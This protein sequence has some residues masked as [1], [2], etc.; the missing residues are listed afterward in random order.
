[1]EE[2]AVDLVVARLNRVPL[3]GSLP[4]ALLLT[5]GFAAAQTATS[6]NAREQLSTEVLE[7]T[8]SELVQLD[9]SLRPKRGRT[10][11]LFPELTKDDFELEIEGRP[12]EIRYAD[13]LCRSAADRSAPIVESGSAIPQPVRPNPATFVFYFELK[14]LTMRGLNT[15]IEMAEQLIPELIQQGDRGIL[16]SSGQNMIQSE[17]TDD[18]NTLLATLHAIEDDPAQWTDYVYAER[19]DAR[20]MEVVS[21]SGRFRSGLARYYQ[22]EEAMITSNRLR[23]LAAMLG[24]LAGVDPPKVVFYFADRIR[25]NAG[26]HYLRLVGEDPMGEGGF[27]ARLALDHVAEQAGAHGLRFYTVAV[28]GLTTDNPMLRSRIQGLIPSRSNRDAEGTLR[29]RALETG[30]QMFMGGSNQRVPDRREGRCR[31]GLLLPAQLSA[32]RS[33]SRQ[34]VVG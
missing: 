2:R 12:I 16:V 14:H 13:K 28:K 9:V 23:R 3:F 18:P 24:S 19:E 27:P 8:K 5:A 21:S 11:E 17:P 20:V 1:M 6:A 10:T 33:A 31:S 4:V 7:E 26:V 22:R 29:T 34:N 30:G 32:W 15:A 25:S